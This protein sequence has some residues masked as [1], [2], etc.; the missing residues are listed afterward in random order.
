MYSEKCDFIIIRN[1][2][3]QL[4]RRALCWQKVVAVV[5]AFIP[6]GV[7]IS[8]TQ[9]FSLREEPCFDKRFSEAKTM[10]KS[11]KKNTHH[12]NKLYEKHSMC[13]LS[14]LM[15]SGMTLGH[16][17]ILPQVSSQASEALLEGPPYQHHRLHWTFFFACQKYLEK[18]QIRHLWWIFR[19]ESAILDYSNKTQV[20]RS[21]GAK[22]PCQ[23]LMKNANCKHNINKS[24]T[25][26][27]KS[28]NETQETEHCKRHN[29]PES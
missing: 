10:K 1:L 28:K 16:P 2:I 26:D 20:S 12:N 14:N 9:K 27:P 19:S 15:I 3:V 4:E 11:V 25:Q 21:F 18:K 5:Q 13:S 7:L 29:G 23:D 24:G 6:K 17:S 22:P 8:K